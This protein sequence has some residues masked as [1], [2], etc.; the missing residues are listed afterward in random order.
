MSIEKRKFMKTPLARGAFVFYTEGD[1]EEVG[2]VQYEGVL[3]GACSFLIIGL[4][5]P[6]VIQA[7]YHLSKRVWPLF[8]LAGGLLILA[9]LFARG[10][11]LSALL[12]I[13]GFSCLWSVRELYEQEERVRKGWFPSK[14]R[15]QAEETPPLPN[16]RSSRTKKGGTDME[17]RR[18]DLALTDPTQI[19][20]MI[21]SCDCFRLAFADGTRPYILP[22]SFGYE[23][24][25][26]TQVF[27]YH[28]AAVGRKVDL[29]RKL[30]YAGFELDAKH[31]VHKSENP[32]DF[33]FGYQ[34]VIGEGRIEELT[35]PQEK[36]AALRVIMQHYSGKGD[37]EFPESVL[38]K[39]CV[40]RLTVTEL[41]ARTHA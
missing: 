37:W 36:M 15:P 16:V 26:D 2:Q 25:G 32:C 12:G 5:H 39:T 14:A 4:F 7:E 28:G 8:V 38:A 27:Y 11:A 13:A 18:Q 23:R 1:A 40:F 29:S 20:A 6:L 21:Q 35:D 33:S 3:I 34:S 41:S 17:M 30:A 10:H 19:D 22:L 31:E 9:S 24:K